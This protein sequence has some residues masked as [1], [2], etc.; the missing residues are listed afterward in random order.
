MRIK[1]ILLGGLGLLAPLAQAGELD[2][3]VAGALKDRSIPA[4]AVP[5]GN[6]KGE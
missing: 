3:L 1:Y 6:P 4:M 2:T 5:A